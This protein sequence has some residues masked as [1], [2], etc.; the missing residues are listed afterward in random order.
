MDIALSTFNTVPIVT[1]CFLSQRKV[2][3]LD[4]PEGYL[5]VLV[6][7]L[8]RGPSLVILILVLG[9]TVLKQY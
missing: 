4:C 7:T 1:Q 3:V 5:Q 8:V 2:P 6:L 9:H